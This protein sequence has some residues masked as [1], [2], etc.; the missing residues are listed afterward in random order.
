MGPVDPIDS[1]PV[2]RRYWETYN[3]P[4]SGCGCLWGILIILL[5]IWLLSWAFGWGG[6][7][8]GGTGTGPVVPR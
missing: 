8:G 6:W 4:Y 1:R 5:I 3:R 7:W 2:Y